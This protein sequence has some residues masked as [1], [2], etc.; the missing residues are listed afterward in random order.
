MNMNQISGFFEVFMIRS[1]SSNN[2][3]ADLI[4]SVT[5]QI[6]GYLM[7]GYPENFILLT[8]YLIQSAQIKNNSNNNILLPKK[9]FNFSNF[10]N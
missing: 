6:F 9:L 3:S 5:I 10:N 4:P 1:V 7:S 8:G 2:Q